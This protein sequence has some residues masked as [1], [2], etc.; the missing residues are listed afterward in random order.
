MELVNCKECGA[1]FLKKGSE[2]I[3]FNCLKKEMDDV[4]VIKEFA[5]KAQAGF[6]S[7]EKIS[8]C[9]H[10]DFAQVEKLYKKGLLLS[11]NDKLEIRCQFCGAELRG[12]DNKIAVCPNCSKDMIGKINVEKSLI[13]REFNDVRSSSR[14]NDSEK[15]NRYGFKKSYD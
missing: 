7:L 12:K 14:S 10:I 9:T 5:S 1:P 8:E 6:F 2:E 4:K 15:S 11:I 3:C 13:K